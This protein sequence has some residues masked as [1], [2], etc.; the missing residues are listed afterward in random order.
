[1][2]TQNR[3]SKLFVEPRMQ[4]LLIFKVLLYWVNGFLTV[5]LLLAVWTVYTNGVSTSGELYAALWKSMGPALAA[6][7]VL[8]PLIVMDCIRWS[9]RYAGPMV[10][11]HQG[12]KELA[13]GQ[14][15]APLQFRQSDL[16]SE[17]AKEFNRIA[18]RVSQDEASPPDTIEA[19][20]ESNHELAREL[21]EVS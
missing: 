11:L 21:V 14:S 2:T 9:N 13:A 19:S 10:R 20:D 8:L 12:L 17:M 16:W 5:G 15:V 1:M 6:S 18:V 4:G 7:L 3:R